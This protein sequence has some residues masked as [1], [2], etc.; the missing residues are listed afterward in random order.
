M[1][2]WLGLVRRD[3]WG[4]PGGSRSFSCTTEVVI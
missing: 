1:Q 3:L 2:G 4:W